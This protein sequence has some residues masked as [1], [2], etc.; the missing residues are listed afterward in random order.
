[1]SEKEFQKTQVAES[2]QSDFNAAIE[3]SAEASEVLL[4]SNG[5]DILEELHKNVYASV[6]STALIMIPAT[7]N[8]EAILESISDPEAFT[9]NLNTASGEIANLVKAVQHLH[10]GHCEREGKPLPEDV[11]MISDLALEYSRIQTCMEASVQ[12]LL[13]AMVNHMQEA[14]IDTEAVFLNPEDSQNA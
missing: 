14:G 3:K 2:I 5:W 13:L 10:N 11:Q 12:P 4:V 6:V 1:M 8:K 9:K 7:K